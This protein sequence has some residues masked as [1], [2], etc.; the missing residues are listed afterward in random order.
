MAEVRYSGE[1]DPVRYGALLQ[2]VQDMGKK[3]DKLERVVEELVELAN[4]SKGGIWLGMAGMSTMTA[5][6]GFLLNQWK[7]G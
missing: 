2:E 4:K 5:F 7:G 3:I 1:I 6:I